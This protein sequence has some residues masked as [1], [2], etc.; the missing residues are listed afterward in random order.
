[1][2]LKLPFGLTSA[3]LAFSRLMRPIKRT[4]RSQRVQVSW[5]LDDFLK[6]A[7]YKNLC[8]LHT[9]WTADLLV[10][11][12]FSINKEKSERTPRQSI[13][14]LGVLFNLHTCSMALPPEQVH[15]VISQCEQLCHSSTTTRRILESFLGLLNFAGPM[16]RLGKLF[17][18][19][20][21]I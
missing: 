12:G 10:W 11:L 7:L 20:I 5:N 8:A 14:Y 4:L 9:T 2:F 16:L 21:I 15:N 6:V 18:T 3:P 1:M 19:P 13:V 17:T